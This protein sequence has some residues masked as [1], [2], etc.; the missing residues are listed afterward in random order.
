MRTI[1]KTHISKL[2]S[3]YLYQELN[4]AILLV[5]TL[6]FIFEIVRS[7]CV[8]VVKE[9]VSAMHDAIRASVIKYII[10]IIVI[11]RSSRAFPVKN[12]IKGKLDLITDYIFSS[13]SE[14]Q[15]F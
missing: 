5:N 11:V 12:R 4:K 2:F 3:K 7:F 14:N 8:F 9:A 10:G 15:Q 6:C 13:L 1:A